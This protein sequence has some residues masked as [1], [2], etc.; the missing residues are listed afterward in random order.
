M[1]NLFKIIIWV[2]SVI[3]TSSAFADTKMCTMDYTPVCAKVQVQ[4][5]MAPC[6]PVYETF[7]NKCEMGN[8]SLATYAYDWECSSSGS[9]VDTTNSGWIEN[10]ANPASVFC[11]KNWWDLNLETW[12]CTFRNGKSCNEWAFF[13]WECK[14]SVDSKYVAK[15]V[16]VDKE[17]NLAKI[18]LVYPKI[19]NTVID[20]QVIKY[21]NTVVDDFSKN[22]GTGSLSTNWKNEL[23]SSYEV[24][25]VANILTLK[26]TIYEFTGWA[27]GTTTI[28]T[29]NFDAKTG[30]ELIIRN[31][32]FIK[33]V[34][35]YSI[36]YFTDLSEKNIINSDKD[37]IS[38]WLQPTFNN[39]SDWLITGY[40]RE[41]GNTYLKFDFIFPQ[42]QIAPYSDGIQTVHIDMKDLK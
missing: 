3:I 28:K 24:N 36:N 23:D 8:N 32:K 7:S 6:N 13:R 4:C 40:Y 41:N 29:F 18:Y 31:S 9:A 26:L 39:F 1:K 12:D 38:E 10:M 22:I 20:A 42:Y 11:S 21:M 33:K 15:D 19:T 25:E 5:I 14:S 34:S 37:W 35:D 17:N 16:I 30:R 2:V 27:H